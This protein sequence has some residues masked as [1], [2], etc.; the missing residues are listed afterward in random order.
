MIF[1]AGDWGTQFRW[2][3]ADA[4]CQ[5]ESIIRLV[6]ST[7]DGVFLFNAQPYTLAAVLEGAQ[8]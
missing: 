2:S 5:A 4:A 3:F 8:Q 6:D 7:A 1:P